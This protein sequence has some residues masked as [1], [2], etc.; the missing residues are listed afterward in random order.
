MKRKGAASR[1]AIPAQVLRQLNDGVLET[2]SLA[3]GLAIDFDQLLQA[4]APELTARERATIRAADGVTKRMRQVGELLAEKFGLAGVE[5][6]ASHRS[7]TVRGWAAYS[8]AATPRLSLRQ[9]LSHIRP[10]A[11]DHHFGVREWAWC[12]LRVTVAADVPA[13]LALL[14]HWAGESSANL[15]RFA[16]EI[17]RPRGVWC[18][19]LPELKA[20]PQLGLS[21]LEPLRSDESKY[22]RDSVGNWLN[23]AAK[24]QPDWVRRLCQQWRQRSPTRE[25]AYII[26]RALRSLA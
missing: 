7:D 19:H 16:S 6:F 9:R 21:L 1:E 17:T 26:K 10:L 8:I 15:R 23:D 22:V 5:R 18:A 4:A 3:E 13:A 20:K 11:D 24:S 2:A 14:E 25:T 12:A